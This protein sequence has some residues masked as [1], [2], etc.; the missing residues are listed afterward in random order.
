MSMSV[1]LVPLVVAL[2]ISS[3]ETLDEVA[4]KCKVNAAKST[5]I[6]TRFNDA[7]LLEQT[8]KEHGLRVEDS[9]ENRLT[10]V[11]NGGIL[12]YVRKSE[13]EPFAISLDKVS[14]LDCLVNDLEE[15]ETEYDRN[16]Q[17]FT[18]NRLM[19]SLPPDMKVIEDV[20]LDDET[21]LVTLE[22]TN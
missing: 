7:K 12:N 8:L 13:K 6:Q 11:T 17:T 4:E 5:P 9:G 14:N 22:V 20:V 1:L 21:I 18:Y 2:C 15:L 19:H 16:V 10:V 3:S